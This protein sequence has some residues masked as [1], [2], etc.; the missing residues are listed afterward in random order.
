MRGKRNRQPRCA[1]LQTKV[2]QRIYEQVEAFA[3]AEGHT[4][5]SAVNRILMDWS[6]RQREKRQPG[7]VAP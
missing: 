6:Q 5:S 7:A 4:M 1:R 3:I 2:E